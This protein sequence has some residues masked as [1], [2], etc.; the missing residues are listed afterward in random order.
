MENVPSTL[1]PSPSHKGQRTPV[2]RVPPMLRA[3]RHRNFRLFF[4]GQLVS[5]VGTWMQTV[6]QSWLVYR[7]TD[8]ALLLG[9][10]G[11]AS[12]IPVF[13]LAPFGGAV[14]DRYS[15]HRVVVLAQTSMMALALILAGLTLTG[16]VEVWQVIALA[17]LFGAANAFDIP[18]RQAFIVDIVGKK[19]LLNAIALNSSMFNGAR[20]VGPAVAGVLVARFGEG[21]CFFAN[22]VSYLA[23]IGGLLSMSLD[24]RHRQ[25]VDGTALERVIEGFRYAR[26]TAPVRAIL[27]LVALVSI[28]GMPYTVL[29]PVFADRILH[30]GARG[31]GILMGATGLGALLGALTLAARSGVQGLGR[32]IAMACAGFGIS[33]TLFSLSRS[34]W[35]AAAFLV[36]AGFSMI[37]QMASSNTL[38]QAMVPDHLRG[39]VM[40]L[41]SMSFMGMAPFGALLSGAVAH[42]FGAPLTVG[43]GAGVCVVGAGLFA[44]RLP[45]LRGEARQLII[46]QGMLGGEPPEEMTARGL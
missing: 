2:H 31:L 5:L 33:L 3:L 29:M 41:Y 28:V 4:G 42:G 10:V 14:A 20:V 45:S 46:A 19:D 24:R 38:L 15:R 16:L 40:A 43:L 8:S 27:L 6:A 23:V 44:L 1:A 39:R 7:L 32:L 36:P 34:F 26:R 35:P 25:D 13:V 11:F 37:L 12:Q 30:S 22:G 9:V 17:L 18:A 21:W